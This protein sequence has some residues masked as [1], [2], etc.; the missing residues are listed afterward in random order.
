VPVADRHSFEFGLAWKQDN[1]G[2]TFVLS[3]IELPHLKEHLVRDPES[4]MIWQ[5]RGAS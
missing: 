3:P 5:G 4:N 2:T 1:N